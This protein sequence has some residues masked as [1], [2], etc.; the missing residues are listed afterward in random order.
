MLS[1]LSDIK[2]EEIS[3]WFGD[4]RQ[5]PEL[6]ETLA[7]GNEVE[8]LG[9]YRMLHEMINHQQELSEAAIAIVPFLI[10]LLLVEHV[11][12][13]DKILDLLQ[14]CAASGYH[15]EASRLQSIAVRREVAKGMDLYQALLKYNEPEVQT[16]SRR[17]IKI[18]EG[19]K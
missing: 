7:T 12:G 18:L 5:I 9:A 2:W 1:G 3:T 13:K 15:D 8:R 14:R 17:L 4:P 10:E 19:N 6:L 11:Q 16:E